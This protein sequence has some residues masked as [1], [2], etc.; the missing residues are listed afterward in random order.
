MNKAKSA[1]ATAQQYAND[2]ALSKANFALLNY[3]DR[4]GADDWMDAVF[5]YQFWFTRSMVNWAK[6]VMNKP[7]IIS[8]YANRMEHMERMGKDLKN[9]PLRLHGRM[10]IPWPFAEDWMGENIYI[11][12]WNELMPVNQILAPLEYLS[13]SLTIDPTDRLKMMLNEKQITQEEYDKAIEEKKGDLWD[14]AYKLAQMDMKDRTRPIDLASMLMSPNWLLTETD[15]WLNDR[16]QRNQP[17]TNLGFTLQSHGDRIKGNG[18]EIVGDALIKVGEGLQLPEKKLRGDRFIYY[19]KHGT[20]LI[21][22][23]LSNMAAE[24]TPTN[25]CLTAMIEQKGELWDEASGRVRDQ[26]SL[27]TPGSLLAQAME[28]GDLTSIPLGLL[29]TMF[30]AGIFPEGELK[31]K[32]LYNDFQEVIRKADAGDPTAMADWFDE[33][34]EYLVRSAIN[35]SPKLKLKKYFINQIMDYYTSE[36]PKNKTLFK[37]HL[38]DAFIDKILNGEDKDTDYNALSLEELA[39]WARMAKAEIPDTPDT[40]G[41]LSPLPESQM[42]KLLNDDQLLEINT[43]F[44]ERNRLF[45]NHEWQNR[46]YHNQATSKEKSIFLAKYPELK[47]YWEWNKAYKNDSPALKEWLE[48]NTDPVTQQSFDPYYG[49]DPEIIDGY[50]AQKAQAFPNSQWLNQE[51]WGIPEENSGARRAFLKKYPELPA[52]WDWKKEVEAQFPQI[53]YYNSQVDIKYQAE[54]A[55][56][57]NPADMPPNKIAEALDALDFNEYVT[58]DLL[59]YY[60]FGMP[61]PYGSMSYL[62]QVWENAGKPDTLMKYIDNLF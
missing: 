28:E 40:S 61:I 34:P 32:G 49:V 27:K 60:V 16:T 46:A 53:K 31:Q 38:G 48:R 12:P 19:D 58:Q 24:G 45:P 15:A 23:E 47:Y 10:Q 56:P 18:Y 2:F 41:Y 3:N 17:M 43:Y 8:Q 62:K 11:N 22:R 9:Y 39:S 33:H 25:D 29:L 54:E 6:R 44:D 50:R 59:N 26:F 42:P 52:Y 1:M 13:E 20:E 7:S 37:E 21:M 55:F 51:Y 4:T 5:P 30:P 14:S 35:D 36:D 57:V